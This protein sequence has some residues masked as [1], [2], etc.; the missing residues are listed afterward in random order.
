MRKLL[1]IMAVGVAFAAQQATAATVSFQV[2]NGGQQ[3]PWPGDHIGRVGP[4]TPPP[5][6]SSSTTFA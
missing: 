6:T 2:V 1:S 5:P 4:T 3:Q